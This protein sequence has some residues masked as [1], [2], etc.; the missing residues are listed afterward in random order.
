MESDIS[1]LKIEVKRLSRNETGV[2][3]ELEA[4]K[5]QLT[6][7]TTEIM[8]LLGKLEGGNLI[9]SFYKSNIWLMKQIETLF[10]E[11]KEPVVMSKEELDGLRSDSGLTNAATDADAEPDGE[12]DE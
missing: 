9:I 6:E 8:F 4:K 2:Q 1:E 10:I 11:E 3:K 12:T 7:A 5:E